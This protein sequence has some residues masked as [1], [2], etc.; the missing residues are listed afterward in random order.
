MLKVLAAMPTQMLIFAIFF[1]VIATSLLPKTQQF[2]QPLMTIFVLI[3]YGLAFFLLS[4]TVKS[5]PVSIAYAVWCGSGILLVTMI[6][7]LC[8]GQQLDWVAMLGISFILIGSIII[9]V[10]SKTITH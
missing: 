7:W 2:T 10:F 4:I 5:I 9:N 3:C 8:Y 6:S 1:E